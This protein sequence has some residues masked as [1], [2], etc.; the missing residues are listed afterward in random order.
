M[1]TAFR[2]H[3]KHEK[4]FRR[5]LCGEEMILC[6]LQQQKEKGK[7][8]RLANMESIAHA[9]TC[10][11]RRDDGLQYGGGRSSTRESRWVDTKV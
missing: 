7:R 6:R 11:I 1:S 10:K 2:Y 5:F 4:D 9:T 8:E 3:T